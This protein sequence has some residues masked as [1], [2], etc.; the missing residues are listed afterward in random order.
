MKSGLPR[1]GTQQSTSKNIHSMYNYIFRIIHFL[2]TIYLSDQFSNQ[3]IYTLQIQM[4]EEIWDHNPRSCE[5][6]GIKSWCISDTLSFTP[7]Y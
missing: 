2:G 5:M 3:H 6:H 4:T 1:L 7:L